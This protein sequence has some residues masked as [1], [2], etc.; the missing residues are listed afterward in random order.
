MFALFARCE[1]LRLVN[2]GG[3]DETSRGL[4][5]WTQR[6]LVVRAHPAQWQLLDA[7][8]LLIRGVVVMCVSEIDIGHF[9]MISN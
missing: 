5:L 2:L 4:E 9:T 3:C 6:Q 8:L 1:A 7:L